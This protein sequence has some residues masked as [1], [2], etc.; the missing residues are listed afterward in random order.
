LTVCLPSVSRTQP[1][2]QFLAN[3]PTAQTW[4]PGE[5]P[6][7]IPDQV[8]RQVVTGSSSADRHRE[9]TP[10]PS[11]RVV[12]LRARQ[13]PQAANAPGCLGH[14][15]KS[16]NTPCGASCRLPATGSA[17]RLG[18]PWKQALA[19]GLGQGRVARARFVVGQFIAR[20]PATAG[21]CDTPPTGNE[22]PDYEPACH[23]EMTFLEPCPAWVC[24][25]SR[26]PSPEPGLRPIALAPPSAHRGG[27]PRRYPGTSAFRRDDAVRPMPLVPGKKGMQ[28]ISHQNRFDM[29]GV[30]SPFPVGHNGRKNTLPGSHTPNS[31]PSHSFRVVHQPRS[32]GESP[33][34][35][36]RR[37]C[38][39]AN[40]N[41]AA[42]SAGC[43]LLARISG[44]DQRW[45]VLPRSEL[46]PDFRMANRR[47][48]AA[49]NPTVERF[50]SLR[51]SS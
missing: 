21:P 17:T 48:L 7:P 2:R 30:P 6:L 38:F 5:V 11:S 37:F 42:T 18:S 3:P 44:A 43:P 33:P 24:G 34:R 14:G 1:A 36:M 25:L 23:P 16:G 20:L 39:L 46:C 15:S 51:L 29:S 10:S 13:C 28:L 49:G 35:R 50:R 26:T 45:R 4:R 31:L 19:S 47:G 27:P 8:F 41:G 12:P 32:S 22:L 40:G 9:E